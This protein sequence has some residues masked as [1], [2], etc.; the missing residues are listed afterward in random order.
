MSLRQ[1]EQQVRNEPTPFETHRRVLVVRHLLIWG[2]DIFRIVLGT[3]R[4][5]RIVRQLSQSEDL[6]KF[7]IWMI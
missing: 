2:M 4:W 7:N 3:E 5:L 1:P 6:Q